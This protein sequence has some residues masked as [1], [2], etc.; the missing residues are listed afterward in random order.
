MT[1]TLSRAG[2]LVTAALLTLAALAG[3][4]TSDDSSPAPSPSASSS[5]SSSASPSTTPTSATPPPSPADDACYRLTF[6]QALA[7]TTQ[8]GSVPCTRPHTTQTYAVGRLSTV[9]DGHL[10]AVDSDAVRRQVAQTCPARL[11]GYLG[12]SV[13][14]VRLSML[15]AVWF[16][17]TVEQSDAG[18]SWYRCDVIAVG[19]PDRL[20]PL[21]GQLKGILT[22]DRADDYAMC[23]TAQPG[24]D[25][26]QRV[27]C[28]EDHSWKALR[29]VALPAGA[30]PGEEKAKAAGQTIC[31]DAGRDVAD[32]ALDYQWGYEWPTKDEWASGQTYGI[33]WAPD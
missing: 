23:S 28:S 4:G 20:L 7:P 27:A 24:T 33:C 30:Y 32:D 14:D 21:D 1:R 2:L 9:V 22:T 5:A 26:F 17:P 15:R 6:D 19:G 10:L 18:A 13:D 25:G 31:R 16:T 12:G 8:T 11:A 29:T 3:C